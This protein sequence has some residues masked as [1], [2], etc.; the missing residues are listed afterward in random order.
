MDP[1]VRKAI[2]DYDIPNPFKPRTIV[3]FELCV[4]VEELKETL[5]RI[6]RAGFVF[7]TATQD[8]DMYTVF[9]WRHLT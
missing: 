3:D 5:H 8:G 9:F 1:K 6:N 2:E 4:G 7:L